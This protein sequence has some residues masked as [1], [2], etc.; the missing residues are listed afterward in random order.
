MAG[1]GLLALTVGG[2]VVALV[3]ASGGFD[4]D[5]VLA[6]DPRSPA[7]APGPLV[8]CGGHHH[9]DQRPGSTYPARAVPVG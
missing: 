5:P 9:L 8:I 7:A 1:I 6:R 3:A 4:D 2:T